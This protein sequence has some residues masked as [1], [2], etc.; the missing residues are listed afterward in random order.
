MHLIGKDVL[1][2]TSAVHSCDQSED[3]VSNQDKNLW[4]R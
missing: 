4:T 1:T 2:Q 3:D